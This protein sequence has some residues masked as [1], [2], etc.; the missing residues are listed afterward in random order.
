MNTLAGIAVALLAFSALPVQAAEKQAN[1]PFLL[2][3]TDDAATTAGIGL[4]RDSPDLG[5]ASEIRIWIG[6]GIIEPEH[7]VRLRIGPDGKVRGDAYLYFTDEGRE[8]DLDCNKL[9]RDNGLL[10]C[11]A[12]LGKSP[13]WKGLYEELVELGIR[14][15][16]DE[17]ELPFPE[18]IVMD[19]IAVVVEVRDGAAYRA[20]DYSNPS[21]RPEPEAQA[22]SRI[23]RIASG[24]FE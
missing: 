12:K 9:H 13:D 17:S 20:Y 19:G 15:L 5:K 11:N 23:I 24:V 14:T 18:A 2:Q 7:M 16:P 21:F 1:A 10:V 22:A 3:F 8:P 4:L 6:F